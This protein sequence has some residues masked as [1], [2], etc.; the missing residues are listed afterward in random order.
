MNT[1]ILCYAAS[2]GL[3]AHALPLTAFSATPSLPGTQANILSPVDGAKVSSPVTV[4]L[5]G[6]EM[7]GRNR[8]GHYHLLID[9]QMPDMTKPL[10]GNLKRFD[11]HTEV[12]LYLPPGQHTLQL[13]Y[14]NHTQQP[15]NPPPDSKLVSIT[16]E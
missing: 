3:T 2:L 16:V 8:N 5:D 7:A 1:K 9:G 12:S 14:A 6:I 13:V 15:V 10:G 4:Q 11:G